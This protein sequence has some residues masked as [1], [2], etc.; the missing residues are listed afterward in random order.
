M[1]VLI[2]DV[3]CQNSSSTGRIV[4][5]TYQMLTKVG[6]ECAVCYGRGK[7]IKNRDIYKFGIDIETVIHALLTRITGYTGCFSYFSTR[8]L[9]KFIERFKPDVIHVHELHAYFINVSTFLDYVAKNDI[10]AIFTL[11]CEFNYTGKCG[12][13][14]E[15]EL[16]RTGCQNCPNVH[17][18]PC[19]WF[20]DKTNYMFKKK[21]AAF[22]SLHNACITAVSPWLAERA[23]QSFLGRN[24]VY[25]ICNGVDTN[26]FC[27]KDVTRLRKELGVENQRIIVAVGAQIQNIDRGGAYIEQIASELKDFVFVIVGV[28][29]EVKRKEN[30]IYIPRINN[31]SLLA[32]YYSLGEYFLICSKRETFSMPCAE[33]LCCGTPVVGFKCGAPETIFKQPY[34]VFVEYGDVEQLKNVIKRGISIDASDVAEYGR[35]FSVDKMLNGYYELYKKSVCNDI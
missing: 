13:A 29:G 26:V 2:I 27:P 15:C 30:I 17:E 19:S 31:P 16:W 34:A 32:E 14:V 7:G 11:H 28:D 5:Q 4:Y 21:K 25:T 12:S 24:K 20:F 3:N 9:I 18:Y 1:K 35:S 8:R 10:K 33:A 6:E 23:R 22:E